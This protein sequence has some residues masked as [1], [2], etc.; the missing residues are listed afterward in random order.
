LHTLCVK[1]PAPARGQG[2]TLLLV[3]VVAGLALVWLS[4]F[5][6]VFSL[7]WLVTIAWLGRR[8]GIRS[9]LPGDTEDLPSSA[10]LAR[11]RLSV[12]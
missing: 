11:R 1:V 9:V 7:P 8:H 3:F 2:L 6:L 4:L 5:A 10:E 12:R